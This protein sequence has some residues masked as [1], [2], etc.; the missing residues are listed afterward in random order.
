M[1][2]V[3]SL[4][5]LSDEQVEFQVKDRLSF[6]RFLGISLHERV[7]DAKTIWRYRER[8]KRKKLLDRLFITFNEQ[9]NQQGYIAMSGTI[10]DASIIQSPRQHLTKKE[11]EDITSGKRPQEW[12]KAK[13]RQKDTDATYTVRHTKKK[14][15]TKNDLIIPFHGYKTHIGIDH[16]HG[17]IRT[18]EVT[19]A[20][21][22]DGHMLEQLMDSENTCSDVYADTAY[23]SQKNSQMLENKGFRSQIHKKKPRLK[24]MPVKT[25]QSNT[26]KSKIWAKVEHVFAVLKDKMGLFIRTIGIERA[27]IKI[28]LARLTYNMKRLVHWKTQRPHPKCAWNQGINLEI[29]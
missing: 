12:S 7:P 2:V 8:L 11:K 14:D 20:S 18:Q 5:N 23:Q 10:V 1:L 22:F 6:M 28:Q 25:K 16:K 17:F 9:L 3:Q 26:R 19:T 15:E 13:A 27:T 24:A 21:A 4:Y 29:G